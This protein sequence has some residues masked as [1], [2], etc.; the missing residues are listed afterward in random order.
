[1]T[2]NPSKPTECGT[3]GNTGWEPITQAGIRL[4]RKCGAC[5]YWPSRIHHVLGCPVSDQDV[6]LASYGQAFTVTKDN[7]DPIDQGKH[8]VAG[9][10]PGLY[11][12]GGTG[13]G[14]T[15][16][17]L[18]IANT[19][20]RK[21]STGRFLRVAELL[22]RLTGD[23]GDTLFQVVIDVPILVLDDIG[24][25]QGTDYARRMLLSIYDARVD[26][27]HRTIWT[28][29]LDLDELAEFLGEDKRL[30]SRIA[31]QCKTVELAGKDFRLQRARTR[32]MK[33]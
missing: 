4:V 29:N 32:A 23:G 16:L 7:L 2:T 12:H 9:V 15:V 21:G 33:K 10:H 1:M 5:D 6:T 17:A 25:N 27:G 28:S 19:L 11:I 26:K 20:H 18:A 30:P 13:T 31:G 3:C 24:A 22:T 14:K 8:F